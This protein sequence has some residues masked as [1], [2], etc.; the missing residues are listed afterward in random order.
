MKTITPPIASASR[1]APDNRA[2]AHRLVA[3]VHAPNPTG[4]INEMLNCRNP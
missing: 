4:F 2:A 1:Q 3:L